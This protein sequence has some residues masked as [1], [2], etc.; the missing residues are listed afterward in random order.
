MIADHDIYWLTKPGFWGK[1]WQ[2]E[3]GEFFFAIFLSLYH[4][5]S[6]KL[7]TMIACDNV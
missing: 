5:L 7:R 6:L 2:P 1:K 4:K 3:D